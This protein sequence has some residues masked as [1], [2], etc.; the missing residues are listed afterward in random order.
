MGRTGERNGEAFENY[1]SYQS[2][3]GMD[4][5]PRSSHIIFVL[6]RSVHTDTETHVSS[7][8]EREKMHKDR[9]APHAEH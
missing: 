4:L 7:E 3:S 2:T 8:R 6:L 5:K 9:T 1:Y